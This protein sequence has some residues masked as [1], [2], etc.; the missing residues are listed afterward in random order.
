[1]PYPYPNPHM[2][3]DS[4][5]VP[6]DA[7]FRVCLQDLEHI[8]EYIEPDVANAATYSHRIYELFL[9][10]ATE[11]EATCKALIPPTKRSATILDFSQLST[12]FCLPDFW[13]GF[14]AGS[15]APLIVQPFADWAT[16]RA[17]LR[18]YQAY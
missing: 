12:Q 9:R 15:A 7:A 17:A 6:H 11:F 14:A 3:R 16:P 5:G 10:V 4:R 2:P 18:W 1:M 8:F 13:V